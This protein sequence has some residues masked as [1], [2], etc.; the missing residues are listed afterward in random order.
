MA[1]ATVDMM[2]AKD[3]GLHNAEPHTPE[4]LKPVVLA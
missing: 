4:V 3:R 1:Q 2:V